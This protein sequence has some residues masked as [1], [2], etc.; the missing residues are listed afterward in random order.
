MNAQSHSVSVFVGRSRV[1]PRGAAWAAD[2]VVAASRIVSRLLAPARKA[3]RASSEARARAELLKLA[4]ACERAQ[5]SFAA[6]LR[7][8]STFGPR[9]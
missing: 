7:A 3:L 6:E 2:I 8:V 5:P 9:D 1:A 4:D